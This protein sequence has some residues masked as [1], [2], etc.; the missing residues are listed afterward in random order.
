MKQ[1]NIKIHLLMFMFSIYMVCLVCYT[2]GASMT[3]AALVG[4]MFGSVPYVARGLSC[5]VIDED[6]MTYSE[7]LYC[8]VS[9]RN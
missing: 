9:E 4:I 5:P 6:N 8:L 2:R 3:T 1:E 7:I